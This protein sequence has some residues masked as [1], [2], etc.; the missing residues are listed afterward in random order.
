MKRLFFLFLCWPLGLRSEE[1]LALEQVFAALNAGNPELAARR[2]EARAWEGRARAQ[3][4]WP[5]PEIGRAWEK[6]PAGDR[7]TH[8]RAAQTVPFP[9]KKFLEAAAARQAARAADARARERALAL[10]AEA[11]AIVARVRRA[12]G[13]IARWTD[14]REIIDGLTASLRGRVAGPRRGMEGGGPTMDLFS[15][16]AE[17]GRMDNMIRME[18]QE[19]AAARY[20]LNA[21]L[22]RPPETPW[23]VADSPLATPPPVEALL[24]MARRENPALMAARAAVRGGALVK[25][26]GRLAWAPDV[27]LMW[28]ESAMDGARGRE[29][30][31]SL[32]LPLWGAP[33]GEARESAAMADAAAAERTALDNEIAR[34]VLTEHA[35]V[36]ARLA[37]ARAFERDILPAS[38]SALEL[39]RRQYESGR[40]DFLRL[41]ESLRGA[42][43]AEVEHQ[44]AVYEYARHWGMLEVAVG[45]PLEG[46][47][48][49][50]E[51]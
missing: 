39:T 2:A 6:T 26:R 33:R 13:V 50:G 36:L 48:T 23:A 32:M 3:G 28:D 27:G 31:V 49:G 15:L 7:M 18:K 21:L 34:D 14:Q 42:S 22:G 11:R 44:D 43:Q 38:R 51:K 30:G 20:R 45:A 24:E 8:W 1:P 5:D 41:L 25:T 10:R 46:T 9:G 29:V 16:E 4:A 19:R 37:A 35:E 12:D 40:A 47:E 17:R